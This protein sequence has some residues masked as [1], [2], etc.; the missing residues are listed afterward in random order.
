MRFQAIGKTEGLKGEHVSEKAKMQVL[1]Q[2]GKE[3]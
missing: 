2:Q 3:E 1:F